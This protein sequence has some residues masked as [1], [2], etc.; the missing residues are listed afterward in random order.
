MVLGLRSSY[1]AV[2]LPLAQAPNW[3]MSGEHALHNPFEANFQ[4]QEIAGQH[5]MIKVNLVSRDHTQGTPLRHFAEVHVHPQNNSQRD[6]FMDEV[7]YR[8][9]YEYKNNNGEHILRPLI[10]FVVDYEHYKQ[11][12]THRLDLFLKGELARADFNTE[13]ILAAAQ[14]RSFEELTKLK[15]AMKILLSEA[16]PLNHQ[17]LGQITLNGDSTTLA[18]L[19]DRI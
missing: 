10:S 9:L 16:S 15:Q 4:E 18:T 17:E 8:K 6:I 19:R 13:A 5:S 2:D 14:M 11:Q 7:T 3:L 1:S 12:Q